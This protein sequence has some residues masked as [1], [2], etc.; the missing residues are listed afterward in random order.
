VI[1]DLVCREL[2]NLFESHIFEGT[3]IFEFKFEL[4]SSGLSRCLPE[5]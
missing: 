1:H 4:R 2:K 5:V 3:V